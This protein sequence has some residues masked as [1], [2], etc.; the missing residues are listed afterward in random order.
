MA[1]YKRIGD[2]VRKFKH[3][4]RDSYIYAFFDINHFNVEML[5]IEEA[6]K[7]CRRNNISCIIP[8]ISDGILPSKSIFK[9]L[10]DFYGRLI[11]IAKENNVKVGLNLQRVIEKSYFLREDCDK[12]ILANVLTR[13]EYYHGANEHIHKN[14]DMNTTMAITP[15][16]EMFGERINLTSKTSDGVLDYTLPDGNWIVNY[17]VCEK[18]D[19]EFDRE[20]TCVNRLSKEAYP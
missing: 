1:T 13:L 4:D 19:L 14:V 6:I 7:M 10:A 11:P 16:D 5:K 20:P 12:E 18:K 15:Y 8:S 3:P 9:F 17:Y 2:L